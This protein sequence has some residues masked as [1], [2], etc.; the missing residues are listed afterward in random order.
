[1]AYWKGVPVV[2]VLWNIGLATSED[3]AFVGCVRKSPD[4]TSFR[5][6]YSFI[7]HLL[8]RL[9]NLLRIMVWIGEREDALAV[10]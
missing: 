4:A 3:R 7:T 6:N 2:E 5:F 1:L 8:V 9:G 10:S